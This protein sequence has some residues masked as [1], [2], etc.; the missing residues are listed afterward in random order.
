MNGVEFLQYLTG[1]M[2]RKTFQEDEGRNIWF[3]TEKCSVSCFEALDYLMGYLMPQL[4]Q[5]G[6]REGYCLL[7]KDADRLKEYEIIIPEDVEKPVSRRPYY[8]LRGCPVSREQAL[9][10][11]RRT[12]RYF[13]EAL[14]IVRDHPDYVGGLNFDNWLMDEC[15]YPQGYGWVHAD[16]TIGCDAITQKYP[17]ISEFAT[18]WLINLMEFPYL[19]LMIAVTDYNEIP[20][21]ETGEWID[22][23]DFERSEQAFYSSICLGIHVSG[24]KVEILNKRDAAECY[25]EYAEK[26]E[27]ENRE[28]YLSE[29]YEDHGIRQIGEEQIKA[30]LESFQRN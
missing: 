21:D 1:D 19:D 14:D 5:V 10:L 24:K 9:E 6:E 2:E 11:I 22:E 8:R 18:E 26:Y 23:R 25:R 17:E 12:D 4:V 29:Y 27:R 3:Q 16:G 28:I 30:F 13:Y 15:H 7:K 20:R